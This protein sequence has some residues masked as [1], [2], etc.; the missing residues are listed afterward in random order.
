MKTTNEVYVNGKRRRIDPRQAIGKGG[1]ADIY[2]IGQGQALKLF[3]SPAHP[4]FA[5]DAVVREAARK[6]LEEHQKKLRQFPSH[7]PPRVIAPQ[8]LATADAAGSQIT[9]YV[10]PLLQGA[11]VLLRFGD[12]AY[13]ESSGIE[14]NDVVEICKD[15]HATVTQV[16]RSGVVIGDFNDL[17]VLVPP[18]KKEAFLID[19]D[20][21]QFNAFLCQVFTTRFLDPTLVDPAA[22]T[23]VPSL[24]HNADS[25]WYAFC[26]M[27]M[28]CL[29]YVEPYG[30]L[31][32]P[33]DTTQRMAHHLRPLHRI[34]VF[35]AEVRYPKPALPLETLPDDL[36]Q[37]FQQVFEK[38]RREP[39]P[40]ALLD[41]LRW[42]GCLACGATH[43]RGQCPF[44][45]VA[46]A[47]VQQTIVMRGS[48][49]ATRLFSTS[50]VI[51]CVA[52]QGG[53][54]R[55]LFHENGQFKREDGTVVAQGELDGQTRFGIR[56]EDTLLGRQDQI[57]MLRPGAVPQRLSADSYG[58]QPFFAVNQQHVYWAQ[59]GQLW[60]DGQ[61][62]PDYI[63]DVLTRQTLFWCGPEFGF[64]FYRAGNLSVAFI[65]DAEKTGINDSVPLPA[66]HSQLLD[67]TCVFTPNR[68]W[69]LL[70]VQEQGQLLNRCFVIRQGGTLEAS[71]EA[72]QGDGSWLGSG[73]HGKCAG[74]TFL[75]APTDDGIVRVEVDGSTFSVTKT[76]PDTE[77]FVHAENQLFPGSDGLYVAGPHDIHALK[78]R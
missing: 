4:D 40:R 39:F 36:L 69:L 7:L 68:C 34:T 13:R 46:P 55:Y 26:V 54:L 74:G 64:G 8:L 16:H 73:L 57:I 21:F 38:N 70:S 30:G 65:F 11:E 75:L 76:F 12:R 42:T 44:C 60:H 50:G 71:A 27:L 2:D 56:G 24:P 77:P 52:S 31:Y 66:L 62:G 18:G 1:E 37:F 48:V 9:G 72:T 41:N 15:L 78:I 61:L 23:L 35:H 32:R 22:T 59:D 33:K 51:L 29:L 10:M 47:A 45:H 14:P 28:Q 3:K 53:K 20:S 63:G 58:F 5:T 49:T 17:N 25:D 67:A 43:A 19:A 6:R